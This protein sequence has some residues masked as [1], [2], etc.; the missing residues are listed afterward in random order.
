MK[1]TIYAQRLQTSIYDITLEI[2]AKNKNQAMQIAKNLNSN[3][4]DEMIISSD[5][6]VSIPSNISNLTWFNKH[7]W[8]AE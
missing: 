4:Q 5:E 8:E 2:E 6:A 3:Y 1:Y 7:N